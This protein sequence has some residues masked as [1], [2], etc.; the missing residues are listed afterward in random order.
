ML[1]GFLTKSSAPLRS[2]V[3]ISSWFTT[4]EMTM[5]FVPANSGFDRMRSQTRLPLTSGNM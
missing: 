5:I 3:S 4:P 1:N 2:S